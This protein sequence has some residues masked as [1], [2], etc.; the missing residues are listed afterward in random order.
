MK[1]YVL[2]HFEHKNDVTMIVKPLQSAA[3]SS[4]KFDNDCDVIFMFKLYKNIY[5]HGINVL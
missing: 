3:R 4:V 1:I 2:L 5:F